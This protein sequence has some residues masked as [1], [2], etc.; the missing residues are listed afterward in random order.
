[1]PRLELGKLIPFN[2]TAMPEAEILFELKALLP[3]FL[4]GGSDLAKVRALLGR[5][6]LLISPKAFATSA[7]SR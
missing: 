3:P 4:L 5:L 7:E 1:M 2:A 6:P